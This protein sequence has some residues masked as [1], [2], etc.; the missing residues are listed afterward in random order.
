MSASFDPGALLGAS[1]QLDDG[2]RVR[3]RLARS[4][5]A[6]VMRGLVAA[7]G[8]TAEPAD[9]EVGRLVHSDPRKHCVLAATAL[10]DGRET[11]AGFGSITLDA[12]N[13]SPDVLV[14][15]PDAPPALA[16]LLT[17]ALTG[18]AEAIA[19]ARAA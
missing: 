6:P 5:D 11:L 9:L 3:L 1:Y 13:P 17:D 16:G 7:A 2:S 12:A 15:A 19:R 10:I 18:R 8:H 4:S 14:V